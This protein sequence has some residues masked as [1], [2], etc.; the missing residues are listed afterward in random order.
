[1]SRH[2]GLN[3]LNDSLAFIDEADDLARS[4]VRESGG[5]PV[6]TA[7]LAELIA[8]LAGTNPPLTPQTVPTA[9]AHLYALAR[10]GL[11]DAAWMPAKARR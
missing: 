1:M 2:E 7:D 5:S 10:E 11:L 8:R 3:F 6:R 9:R 4:L